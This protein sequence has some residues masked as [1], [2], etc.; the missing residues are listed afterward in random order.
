MLAEVE[1]NN[2]NQDEKV[3]QLQDA[4]NELRVK[5]SP[6]RV[7]DLEYLIEQLERQLVGKEEMLANLE[8]KLSDLIDSNST[9]FSE[10]KAIEILSKE[11]L[12]KDRLLLGVHESKQIL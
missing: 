12:K 11:L 8:R 1:K 9:L 7:N 4:L 5:F 10:S 6:E 3:E 2:V